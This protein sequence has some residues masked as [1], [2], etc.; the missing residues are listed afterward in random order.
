MQRETGIAA[1]QYRNK[2]VLERA[3][4]FLGGVVVM[5]VQGDELPVDVAMF[6]KLIYD[7]WAFVVQN[8]HLG[9]ETSVPQVY[10]DGRHCVEE[11]ICCS[12]FNGFGNNYIDI[13]VIC[14]HEILHAPA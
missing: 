12:C 14:D 9:M 2:V 6:G 13:L 3:N 11:V 4:G 10:I 1:A 8:L 5:Q 7:G